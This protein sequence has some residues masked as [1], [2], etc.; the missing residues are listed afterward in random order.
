MVVS[1][2]AASP[3]DR[4]PPA[5]L[6]SCAFFESDRLLSALR[7]LEG[8]PQVGARTGAAAAAMQPRGAD[9][10]GHGCYG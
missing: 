6:A 3:G 5:A 1:L 8:M 4:P 10:R 7:F 9:G 2:V